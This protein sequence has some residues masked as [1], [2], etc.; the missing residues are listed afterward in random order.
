[1][2]YKEHGHLG[3]ADNGILVLHTEQDALEPLNSKPI[4]QEYADKLERHLQEYL[5]ILKVVED[6]DSSLTL[7]KKQLL[8]KAKRIVWSKSRIREVL[9]SSVSK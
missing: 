6:F 1:M 2:I 9:G 7:T 4:D 3:L 8:H 5:R